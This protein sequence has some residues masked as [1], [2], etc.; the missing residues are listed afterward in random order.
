[1]DEVGR[2]GRR[3]KRTDVFLPHT[4]NTLELGGSS[5]EIDILD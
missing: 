1:M 4:A 5:Q 2:K 3:M